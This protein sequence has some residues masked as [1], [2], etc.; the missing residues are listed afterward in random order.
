METPGLGGHDCTSRKARS[1]LLRVACL[2]AQ[3]EATWSSDEEETM[4]EEGADTHSD[5]EMDADGSKA[6]EAYIYT[7]LLKYLCPADDCYGTLI[8]MHGTDSY[9]CNMCGYRRT[10]QEFMADLEQQE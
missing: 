3:E 6:D 2:P 9:I 8:P 1:A 4:G 5:Q 10:E 7:F